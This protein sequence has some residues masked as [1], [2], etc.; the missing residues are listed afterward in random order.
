MPQKHHQH[1]FIR[2]KMDFV[3]QRWGSV[4]CLRDRHDS[5]GFGFFSGGGS[6]WLLL[7]V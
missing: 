5:F 1:R 2:G 3:T 6:R 7:L 4:A